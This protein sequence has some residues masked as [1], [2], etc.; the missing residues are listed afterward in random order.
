MINNGAANAQAVTVNSANAAQLLPALF[1]VNDGSWISDTELVTGKIPAVFS[2][3]ENLGIKPGI[4][5][6]IE[7]EDEN[8]TDQSQQPSTRASFQPGL[9]LT[10]SIT[11]TV[12]VSRVVRLTRGSVV[13]APS[14]DTVVNTPFC[15]V[16]I[17][18][19]SV[20]MLMAFRHGVAIFN[21]D[22][23]HSRA[24]VVKAGDSDLVLSPGMHAVVTVDSVKNFA[25]VNPA[26]LIGHH[27][28]REQSLGK[29]LKAFTSA[30]S[31]PQAISA[32]VPLNQLL[33]SQ[34]PRAHKVAQHLLKTTTMLMQMNN[35]E[36]EQVLRPAVTAYKN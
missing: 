35:R 13:F 26:Q 10:G 21:L 32:V 12:G 8:V 2:S 19:K 18:A 4:S 22:D 36:Y 6:V 16:K 3:D 23:A 5:T 1:R 30:F 27:T 17:D 25:D 24:V 28:I 34:E 29:G 31:V 9:P 7:M 33:K 11:R 15:Q 20:V 14:R